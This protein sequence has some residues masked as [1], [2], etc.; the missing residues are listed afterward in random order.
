MK[1]LQ[2]HLLAYGPFTDLSLDL[3]DG[4][5]GFHILYGPNEAGKSTALRALGCLLYGFEKYCPDAYLHK[6]DKLRV[7]ATIRG[8]D[9]I[10]LPFI[11]RKGNKNTLLNP[12]GNPLQDDV[13]A[14]YLA[15]TNLDV[16]FSRFGIDST[17]LR[18]GSTG[19]LAGQGN[20]GT[21]LVSLGLSGS[22]VREVIRS[23]KE[24]AE[25]LFRPRGQNQ[26]IN[27][28]L[29]DYR[30]LSN[31]LRNLSSNLREIT[32]TEAFIDS[33]KKEVE[34]LR[35]SLT[36]LNH[37]KSRL[38]RLN[39]AIPKLAQRKL[40]LAQV[41]AMGKVKILSEDFAERRRSTQQSLETTRVSLMEG[42]TDLERLNKEL[43]ELNAPVEILEEKEIINEYK[44]ELGAFIKAQKDRPR[45]LEDKTRAHTQAEEA[46]RRIPGQPSIDALKEHQ[47]SPGQRQL[48]V[49]LADESGRLAGLRES[50]EAQMIAHTQALNRVCAEL[51]SLPA[52]RNSQGLKAFLES[53][54]ESGDLER[55]C[56]EVTLTLKQNEEAAKTSASSLAGWK[57]SFEELVSLPL[58][59]LETATLYV[60]RFQENQAR[61]SEL[62]RLKSETEKRIKQ[63]EKDLAKLLKEGEVP[64]EEDLEKARQ[65]RDFGWTLVRRA[66]LDQED[67]SQESHTYDSARALPEAYETSVKDTDNISDLLRQ[68]AAK[69]ERHA[70]LLDQRQELESEL[71]KTSDELQYH[72]KVQADTQSE[73]VQVWRET[74][75]TPLSPQEM[76]G[77]LGKVPPILQRWEKIKDCQIQLEQLGNQI[78]KHREGLSRHLTH[79][80]EKEVTEKETLRESFLRARGVV[81]SIETI[82]KTREELDQ[83]KRSLSMDLD[84][85]QISLNKIEQD[86]KSWREK[87]SEAVTALGPLDGVTPQTLSEILYQRDEALGKANEASTLAE[88]IRQIDEDAQAYREKA[89]DLV[90]RIAPDLKSLSA[91]EAIQIVSQRLEAA[92][93]TKT[94]QD[95]LKEQ[96]AKVEKSVEKQKKA[97][98]ELLHRIKSLLQE[99]ECTREEDLPKAEEQSAAFLK[100]QHDLEN[101]NNELIAMAPNGDLSELIREAGE[102]DRDSIEG[103]LATINAEIISLEN[104]RSRLDQE[105]GRNTQIL[106][107]INGND[108]A[109]RIAEEAQSILAGISTDAQRYIRLSLAA[110]ILKDA[111]ERFRQQNQGPLLERAGNIFKA[112]SLGSFSGLETDFG[113]DDTP[114]LIGLRGDDG[115]LRVEQMSDGARD[116]LYLS[117]R[118]SHLEAYLDSQQEKM[119]FIVDDILVHFDDQRAAE[120]LKVLADLSHKTQ[121][122]FFTH[123]QHLVELAQQVLKQEDIFV[124]EL[125]AS[126]CSQRGGT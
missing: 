10:E 77:W 34:S 43:A 99:A 112:I 9:G 123:H 47:L 25:E 110:G 15:G 82:E 67:I 58:P 96:I 59:S 35:L 56:S 36:R 7:G 122:L 57:G 55:I 90:N 41:A 3:S 39:S 51:E 84:S 81:E 31:E 113:E 95:A 94:R 21:T 85:A 78:H 126:S 106:S 100:L 70:T 22:D 27:A 114:I 72:L 44:Q 49:Q 118:L 48:L 20:V 53:V 2:L 108:D 98:E 121:I 111:V 40:Y 50:I 30:N 17:A 116:Q 101:I 54:A 12:E 6:M 64:T 63:N 80:G 42:H 76:M 97:I 61:V 91:Q 37:E 4:N 60:S 5:E 125:P 26:R 105:I 120:T 29:G 62:S 92:L 69:V 109:A 19:I 79:L 103:N 93:K 124:H 75:I 89:L 11:R 28:S 73:W 16:F 38:T 88:R 83:R 102:T 18:E 13:L 104:E 65:R 14:K 24:E 23:L 33:L 68:E 119:P 117:L 52:R 66:W 45:L 74:G 87:W 1:I 46:A 8:T 71:K 115:R 86:E 107:A 32:E